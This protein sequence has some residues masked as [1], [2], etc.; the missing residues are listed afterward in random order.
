[1]GTAYSN[2]NEIL[3]KLHSVS[4]DLRGLYGTTLLVSAQR[5][6]EKVIQRAKCKRIALI[7]PDELPLLGEKVKQWMA[8]GRF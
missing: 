7:D 1:M 3:Y 5:P 4:D 8:T 6:S 2:D